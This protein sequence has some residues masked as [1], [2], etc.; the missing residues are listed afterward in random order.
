M[1]TQ[2]KPFSVLRRHTTR[3][4]LPLS[5][6]SLTA[7]QRPPDEHV[8]VRVGNGFGSVAEVGRTLRQVAL[9]LEGGARFGFSGDKEEVP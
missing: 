5:V 3:D 8:E 2:L 1:A 6:V 7:A 9:L 4:D